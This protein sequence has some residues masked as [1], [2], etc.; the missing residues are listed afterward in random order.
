M[1][2]GYH[3][4]PAPVCHSSCVRHTSIPH[5]VPSRIR[6]D[7]QGIDMSATKTTELGRR[8]NN[9]V[10]YQENRGEQTTSQC[11]TDLSTLGHGPSMALLGR[12]ALHMPTGTRGMGTQ[13]QYLHG[14]SRN[15]TVVSWKKSQ[16]QRWWPLGCF[17]SHSSC[18]SSFK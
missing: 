18:S 13:K 1:I 16:G 2:P 12:H 11:P 15:S 8:N 10:V 3:E 17:A 4:V 14:F 9:L 6:T 5:R 7:W